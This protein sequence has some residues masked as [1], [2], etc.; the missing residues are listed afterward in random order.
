MGRQWRVRV[1]VHLKIPAPVV[2]ETVTV[3]SRRSKFHLESISRRENGSVPI[4]QDT[5]LRADI[6]GVRLVRLRGRI[7]RESAGRGADGGIGLSRPLPERYHRGE[8]NQGYTRGVR[9]RCRGELCLPVS[10]R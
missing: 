6:F 7:A 5:D 8:E 9:R 2:S 3:R 1:Y 4:P 10:R